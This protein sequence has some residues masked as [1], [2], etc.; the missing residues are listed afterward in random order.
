[1]GPKIAL[2]GLVT[3][4]G[5]GL[6]G[7][8]MPMA[9]FETFR[10]F[11]DRGEWVALFALGLGF[12]SAFLA[13]RIGAQTTRGVRRALIVGTAC[14]LISSGAFAH[15]VFVFSYDLPKGPDIGVG[16]TTPEIVAKDFLGDD[17]SLSSLRGKPA[18][19]V[20]YRGH[21]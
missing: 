16:D 14:A 15:Y 9:G 12:T 5:L 19:V 18:V 11:V 3:L 20:F 2:W 7:V 13:R 4:V 10:P 8:W 6:Y 21:W 17:F 1:M